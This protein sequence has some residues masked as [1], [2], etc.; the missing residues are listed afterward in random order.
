MNF[1]VRPV[2]LLGA[3]LLIGSGVAA[4][5][6]GWRRPSHSNGRDVIALMRDR[7]QRAPG[8]CIVVETR[9]SFRSGRTDRWF[10]TTCPPGRRRV[11]L[12]PPD[13]ASGLLFR[14]DSLYEM[15]QGKPVKAQALA[16]ALTILMSDAPVAPVTETVSRLEALGFE[17]GSLRQDTW[18]GRTAWVIGG[19]GEGDRTT[20]QFWIDAERLVLLRLIQSQ[21]VDGAGPGDPPLVREVWLDDYALRDERWVAG[22]LS[23]F[24]N[25]E[26]FLVQ[27]MAVIDANAHVDSLAFRPVPW[28]SPTWIPAAFTPEAHR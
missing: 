23:Y 6:A 10:E 3:I 11:D 1:P 27:E 15:S 25:G 12:L 19:L 17:L 14:G 21:R 13:S 20:N 28:V 8:A 7:N 4:G 2:A 16:H 5:S 9:S 18:R 24:R 26:R 22:E